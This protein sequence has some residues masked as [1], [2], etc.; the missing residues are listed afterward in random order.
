MG[1]DVDDGVAD[2]GHVD[3]PSPRRSERTHR[4]RPYAGSVSER[5]P[6]QPEPAFD[7]PAVVDPYRLPRTGSSPVRYD[8]TLVPDLAA[9]TFAGTCATDARG[10]RRPP[11]R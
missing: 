7:D 11:P 8:L 5:E 6:I 10:R 2:A 1:E 9:A 4:Q 3:G